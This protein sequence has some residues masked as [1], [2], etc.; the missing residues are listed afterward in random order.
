MNFET[1]K[2]IIN[3]HYQGR[4]EVVS[5]GRNR[6]SYSSDSSNFRNNSDSQKD[7]FFATNSP[8]I[9]DLKKKYLGV[10]SSE[11]SRPDSFYTSNSDSGNI[12]TPNTLNNPQDENLDDIDMVVVKPTNTESFSDNSL[13]EAVTVILS[14]EKNGPIGSQG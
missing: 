6:Q 13:Q 12:S 5:G 14:K 4:M 2:N 8:S 10:S 3:N 7:D 11:T 9:E 1:S